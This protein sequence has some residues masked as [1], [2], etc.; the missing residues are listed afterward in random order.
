MSIRHGKQDINVL[1]SKNSLFLI[2]IPLRNSIFITGLDR[3]IKLYL[4]L[5]ALSNAASNGD[6]A[7]E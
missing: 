5:L 3:V 4:E 6:C 1:I 7:S 2:T